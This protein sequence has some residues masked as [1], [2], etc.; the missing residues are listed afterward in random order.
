MSYQAFNSTSEFQVVIALQQI[1]QSSR[2]AYENV[3]SVRLQTFDII[4]HTC[5]TNE[6]LLCDEFKSFLLQKLIK[7]HAGLCR[8][9][10]SG[11]YDD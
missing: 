5:S 11:R 10:T 8:E 4:I 9:L 7:K 6:K 1:Q 2:C 3:S